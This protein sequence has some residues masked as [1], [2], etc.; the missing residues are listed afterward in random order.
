MFFWVNLLQ[1]GIII[2]FSAVKVYISHFARER[3]RK[4][5]I[6]IGSVFD[7]VRNF[8]KVPKTS[9]DGTRLLGP[10]MSFIDLMTMPRV[11]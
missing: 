11:I 5:S 4:R 10:I 8:G 6:F 1:R 7:G 3:A 9:R 2:L